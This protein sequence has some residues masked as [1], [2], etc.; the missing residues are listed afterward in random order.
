MHILLLEP[1]LLRINKPTWLCSG[2]TPGFSAFDMDELSASVVNKAIWVPQ[3]D[4]DVCFGI[5]E[6][7]YIGFLSNVLILVFNLSH[8]DFG[9]EFAFLKFLFLRE[10]ERERERDRDRE[11]ET[12]RDREPEK[13]G[14]R[15]RRATA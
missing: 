12:E 7:I 13:R 2:G 1:L 5:M 9:E 15:R 11:R 14:E 4:Q 10:R 8:L 6:N 3:I